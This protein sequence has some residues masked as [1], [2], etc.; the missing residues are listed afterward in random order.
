MK[1][2]LIIEDEL[3]LC[4]SLKQKLESMGFKVETAQTGEKG[5]DFLKN[6]R[7]DALLTDIRLPD[8][9]GISL[10]KIAKGITPNIQTFVMSAYSEEKQKISSEMLNIVNFFDKPFDLEEIGQQISRNI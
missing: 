6:E 1:K 4:W 3:L 7:F 5:I 10:V 9:N 2:I 8:I